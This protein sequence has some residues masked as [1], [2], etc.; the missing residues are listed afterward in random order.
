RQ[1]VLNAL[2]PGCRSSRG[3][4]GGR[5][6]GPDLAVFPARR[7]LPE[8]TSIPPIAALFSRKQPLQRRAS[9]SFAG[10]PHGEADPFVFEPLVAL[11]SGVIQV[12]FGAVS[13][14]PKARDSRSLRA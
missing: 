3:A 8:T 12:E 13:V 5:R 4:A 7:L 10:R 1:R 6:S 14:R 2:T 9:P 11:M